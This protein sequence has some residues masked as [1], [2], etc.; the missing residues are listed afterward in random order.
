MLD[1]SVKY[2]IKTCENVLRSATRPRRSITP[3]AK[4]INTCPKRKRGILACASGWCADLPCRGNR[5]NIAWS[6]IRTPPTRKA[7]LS[8]PVESRPL[9]RIVRRVNWRDPV[10]WI[11]NPSILAPSPS[12]GRSPPAL[13]G[14]RVK[15]R[16]TA[17]IHDGRECRL[18]P[19]ILGGVLISGQRRSLSAIIGKL[20]NGL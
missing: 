9:F 4:M 16:T 18:P 14:L 17:W 13:P 5:S 1:Q 20:A 10:G 6:A 11:V 19:L 8:A 3:A 12:V 15:T 2:A 7:R